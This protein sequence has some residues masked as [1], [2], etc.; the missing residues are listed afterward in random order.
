MKTHPIHAI[1]NFFTTDKPQNPTHT[2]IARIIGRTCSIFLLILGVFWAATATWQGDIVA[3]FS[4]TAGAWCWHY[5]HRMRGT[6]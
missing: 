4:L 3:L 6:K 1:Q 2:A 5:Q